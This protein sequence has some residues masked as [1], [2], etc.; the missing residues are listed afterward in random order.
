MPLWV[1]E[2]PDDTKAWY[3]RAIQQGRKAD[4]Y[5]NVWLGDPLSMVHM[6]SEEQRHHAADRCIA[7]SFGARHFL[8]Y[9]CS[10]DCTLMHRLKDSILFMKHM[11]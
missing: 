5:H 3:T 2:L 6:R 7:M 10:L 4:D 11:R 9:H 1:A 8:P